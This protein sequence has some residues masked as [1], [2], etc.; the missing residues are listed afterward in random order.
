MVHFH[1]D[2]LGLNSL[3]MNRFFK[4][5]TNFEEL[6][7]GHPSIDKT[8]VDTIIKC[9]GQTLRKLT[10]LDATARHME[11]FLECCP[12]LEIVEI[13][14]SNVAAPNIS[15]VL[16]EHNFHR[17]IMTQ[18]LQQAPARCFTSLVLKGKALMSVSD[19]VT[20]LKTNSQIRY[21]IVSADYWWSEGK[22]MVTEHTLLTDYVST[23]N[24]S[25]GEHSQLEFREGKSVYE[26]QKAKIT[27]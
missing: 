4:H 5:F 13:L 1:S 17:G 19:L 23:W 14:V 15:A 25:H 18:K 27:M 9:T 12:N 21:L 16:A 2:Q 8:C 26:Q 6:K 11:L 3:A 24:S 10:L 20:F 22:M 7:L